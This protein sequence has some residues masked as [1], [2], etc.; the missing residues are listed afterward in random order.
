MKRQ[1]KKIAA[2]FLLAMTIVT[3]FAAPAFAAYSGTYNK[4]LSNGSYSQIANGDHDS[5]YDKATVSVNSGC[6]SGG[7]FYV[8]LPSVGQ[9]SSVVSVSPRTM[10]TMRY[11]TSFSASVSLYGR[12]NH[13]G[14]ATLNG[15]WCVNVR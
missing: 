10:G 13:S 6:V 9:C 11:N 2:A 12:A 14:S 3:G 5:S 8:Y 4:T 7:Y 15:S 1:L